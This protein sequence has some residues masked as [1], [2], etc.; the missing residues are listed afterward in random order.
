MEVG[1]IEF[2]GWKVE[3]DDIAA[4]NRAKEVSRIGLVFEQY[5][6]LVSASADGNVAAYYNILS[7][8][9]GHLISG[10]FNVTVEMTTGE[11]K[12]INLTRALVLENGEDITGL[13]E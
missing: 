13:F 11:K 3:V 5:P 2:E 6:G 12:N 7:E 1:R 10:G 4:L 9:K 8:V